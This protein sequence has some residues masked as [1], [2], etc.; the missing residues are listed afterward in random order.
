[1]KQ[2]TRHAAIA[3]LSALLTVTGLAFAQETEDKV[4]ESEVVDPLEHLRTLRPEL[5]FTAVRSAPA[6]GL[7]RVEIGA[8]SFYITADGRYLI[9]GDMYRIDDDALRNVDEER[10]TRRRAD[11]LEALP[12]DDAVTFTPPGGAVA[13]VN[14]FT[15][16]DCGYCQMLHQS[17]AD[18]HDRGIEIRYLAYP[19]GGEES[20]TWDRMVSAWCSDDRESAITALKA[21]EEIP[22]RTCENPVARHYEMGVASG[23]TGTPSMVL[24]DGTMV[25][26]LVA[27]EELAELLELSP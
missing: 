12:E 26:G 21:G 8:E 9:A 4:V 2:T 13:S 25:P 7:Y 3:A 5:D 15:D 14:V 27:A 16:V 19:R 17:M 23:V 6:E 22:K 1:M 18:Y 11:M 10:R 24:P 20:E